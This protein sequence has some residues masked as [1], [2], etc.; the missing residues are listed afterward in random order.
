MPSLRV[1]RE[2]GGQLLESV[3]VFDVFRSETVGAGRVSLAFAL[4]F[5]APDR[6]LTDGDVSEL[7]RRGIDAVTSAFGA[8]LRR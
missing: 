1:L 6:T 8:E 2:A 4:T 3:R 7:R 5:R